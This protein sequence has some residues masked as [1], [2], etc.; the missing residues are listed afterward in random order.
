MGALTSKVVWGQLDDD[1]PATSAGGAN[2]LQ[3]LEVP[4]TVAKGATVPDYRTTGAA[5]MDLHSL[6]R[7][8]LCC[9]I[10]TLVD[11][12]VAI[13]LPFMLYGQVIGRQGLAAHHNITV[14]PRTVDCDSRDSILLLVTL[15]DETG[16]HVIEPGDCIAR[17]V[18]LPVARP[19][20]TVVETLVELAPT[21]TADMTRPHHADAREGEEDAGAS[22]GEGERV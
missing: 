3:E 9:G 2:P 1:N 13:A 18:I 11:T 4:I 17:L 22:S 16:A 12:G 20:L 19:A 5:G 15:W 8:Q 14:H 7:H 10:P 21:V 6:D